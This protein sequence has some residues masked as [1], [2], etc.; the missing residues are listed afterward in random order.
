M[1]LDFQ[2]AIQTALL[3]S[4]A[5][6]IF[7]ILAGVR[8]INK[9]RKLKFFRMRRDR[10]VR[11]WRLVFFGI[12][13]VFVS[14]FLNNY[15]EPVVYNFFPPTATLTT[16]PTVT[17]TPTIT[18]TP[19]ITDTPTITLTPAITDTPTI[20]PTPR[21]PLAI[22]AEFTSIVTPN[23]E[24]V[25]SPLIFAPRLDEDFQPIDPS[26]IFQNP[27]GKLY[28]QFSYNNMIPGVQWTTL[29]FRNGELVNYETKP[30]D[31][32]FGGWGYSDWDP[33]PHEWMA[34]EYEVRFYVGIEWKVTGIFEVQ[35]DPPTPVPSATPTRT[36]TFTPTI[37]PTQG[38]TNTPTLTP[39]RTP[40]PTSTVTN[41][42]TPRPTYPPTQTLTPS[43]TRWPTATEIP[44]PTLI[45]T[46]TPW[47][48]ATPTP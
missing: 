21:L 29:W 40:A 45:P 39:T 47:N 17:Q 19:T 31:G 14:F 41:T 9:G 44:S 22:E 46:R 6:V 33:E 8:S 26:S 30:W 27:V 38:P 42:F 23:P 34:G 35:G 25:F 28:A 13:M 11:G 32:Q 36:Q 20:T 43:Y 18:L 48:S 10:M 37:T 5:A 24:A 3:L 4:I 12:G 2:T 15:A 16:T 7:S 1:D